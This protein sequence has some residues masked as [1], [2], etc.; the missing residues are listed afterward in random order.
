[1]REAQCSTKPQ[2]SELPKFGQVVRAM[3]RLWVGQIA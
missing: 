3:T 1:M 2:K